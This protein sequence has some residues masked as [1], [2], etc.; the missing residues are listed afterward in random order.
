MLQQIY[1][2]PQYI[3]FI[4]NSARISHPPSLRRVTKMYSIIGEI[5]VNL[6]ILAHIFTLQLTVA[7]EKQHV[8]ILVTSGL[9]L[10][11]DIKIP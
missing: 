1:Q 11:Q 4:K 3:H 7:R 5:E 10:T 6:Y 9:S 2:Y 8:H